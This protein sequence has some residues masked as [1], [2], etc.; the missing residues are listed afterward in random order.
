MPDALPALFDLSGR[1]AVLTG[2]A[3]LLGRQYIRTL[4]SAGA[5]V[6]VADLDGDAAIR[7][8]AAAVADTGGEAMGRAVDVTRQ[9][10]VSAMI[11]TTLSRW[12][13]LDILINN[14]AVDPKAD[15][16]AECA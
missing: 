10:D 2:G 11:D 12:G 4:L 15:V 6:L 5:R 1:T 3:G 7:E 13:R 9:E 8:A 14:A 16:W